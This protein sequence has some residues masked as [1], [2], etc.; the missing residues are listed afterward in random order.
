MEVETSLSC[1]YY[2]SRLTLLEYSPQKLDIAYRYRVTI[3]RFRQIEAVNDVL[4]LQEHD[5][6]CTGRRLW[7]IIGV[8]MRHHAKTV[9]HVSKFH[10]SKINTTY[11]PWLKGSSA[12]LLHLIDELP[13]RSRSS[14]FRSYI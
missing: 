6:T 9:F 10:T 11:L 3:C 7:T 8:I 13:G 2:N 12:L 4:Y 14:S 5:C 1:H